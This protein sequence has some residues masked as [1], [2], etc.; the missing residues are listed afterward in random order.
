MN[1]S[2][3]I[4]VLYFTST[5]LANANNG[6]SIVCRYH[7]ER[8]ADCESFELHASTFGTLE[9]V[10]DTRQFIESLGAQYHPIIYRAARL[11]SRFLRKWIP[12]W[13]WPFLLEHEALTH[14][15]VDWQFR[16]LVDKL[17]PDIVVIDYVLA[18]LFIRSIFSTRVRIVTITLNREAEFHAQMRRAGRLWPQI[19]KSIIAEWRIARFER[20][21]YHN[22]DAVIALSE[23]DLPTHLGSRTV[24]I[25][26]IL[27]R[28]QDR[29]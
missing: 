29:W 28:S 20:S 4:K 25:E 12:A 7:L 3:T 6:G 19:S 26:P 2:R 23:G 10:R 15:D 16:D 1:F 17:K 11:P 13:R 9:Q 22:S 24:A 27:D 5:P 8:L 18:A 21:V 14:R